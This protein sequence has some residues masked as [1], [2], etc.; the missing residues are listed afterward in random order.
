MAF[1]TVLVRV[2]P[3][4]MYVALSDLKSL[5]HDGLHKSSNLRNSF[6]CIGDY[7]KVL[8]FHIRGRRLRYQYV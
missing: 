1:L 8:I 6:D 7:Y 2:V 5:A 3:L 4:I